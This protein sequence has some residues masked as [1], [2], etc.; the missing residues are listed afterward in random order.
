MQS[1]RVASGLE[2]SPGNRERVCEQ[3][4]PT[5]V[6]DALSA[7]R[8][9]RA[10]SELICISFHTQ[11]SGREIARMGPAPEFVNARGTGDR[12]SRLPPKEVLIVS[13]TVTETTFDTAQTITHVLVARMRPRVG[14]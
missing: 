3:D 2:Y 9:S 8:V 13:V 6:R 10:T 12:C 1:R 14:D 7:A 5:C 11:D 4:L